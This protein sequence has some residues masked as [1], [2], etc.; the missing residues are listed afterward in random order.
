MPASYWDWSLDV[1][2]DNSSSVSVFSGPVFD[3][4]TGF[5][6]NGVYVESTDTNNPYNLTGR[7]GGGCLEDGPFTQD[8]FTVNVPNPHCLTRD[9]VPTIMNVWAQQSLVDKVLST[10]DYTEF[11]RAIE[12]V[13]SFDQ[14]NI[15]GSGHFGIGGALGTMGDAYNSPGG[16]YHV[17]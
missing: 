6:G 3:P 1:S 2:L 14:P 10:S 5:G 11:A 12:N 16:M 7:T 9:F 8:Q 13:P 4:E 15:H 17:S